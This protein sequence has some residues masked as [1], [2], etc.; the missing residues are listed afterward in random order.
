METRP[1]RVD[2]WQGGWWHI[3]SGKVCGWRHTVSGKVRVALPEGR[4]GVKLT[5]GAVCVRAAGAGPWGTAGRWIEMGTRVG[6]MS[7]GQ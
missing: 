3:D 2:R 7:H 6:P 1:G 5:P 4:E